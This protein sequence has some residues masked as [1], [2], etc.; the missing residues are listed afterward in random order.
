MKR[1]ESEDRAIDA[2]ITKA[3]LPPMDASEVTD[4][5]IAVFLKDNTE[6][7]AAETEMLRRID[8]TSQAQREQSNGSGD[9]LQFP[10][11]WRHDEDELQIMAAARGQDE[12][13]TD[14]ATRKA[15]A[16]KRRQAIERARRKRQLNQEDHD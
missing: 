12:D 11:V 14:E 6:L 15:I 3:L 10:E 5:E 2:L 4:E 1:T 7:D 13:I 16:E 8:L 9:I